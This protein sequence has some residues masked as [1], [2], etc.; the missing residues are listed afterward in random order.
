MKP[1]YTEPFCALLMPAYKIPAVLNV[2]SLKGSV[3]QELERKYGTRMT[4]DNVCSELGVTKNAIVHKIGNCKFSHHLIFRQLF[5]ARVFPRKNTS[6]WT[7][8]IAT[9]LIEGNTNGI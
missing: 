4:L 1:F 5:D 9:I 7:D 6:F 2:G 3:R 8:K